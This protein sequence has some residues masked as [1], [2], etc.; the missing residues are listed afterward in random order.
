MANYY[1]PG[2]SF[3]AEFQGLDRKNQKIIMNSS[4]F[5]VYRSILKTEEITEG[6]E[7]RFKHMKW[8][9]KNAQRHFL[10]TVGR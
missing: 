7:N 2:L 5:P 3:L 1:P 6:G 8:R 9:T 4:R 10:V